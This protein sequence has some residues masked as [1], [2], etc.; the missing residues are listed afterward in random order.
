MTGFS[1]GMIKVK[2]QWLNIKK[3]M[4]KLPLLLNLDHVLAEIAH[5]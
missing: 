5:Q 3:R 2:I 1:P 4:V